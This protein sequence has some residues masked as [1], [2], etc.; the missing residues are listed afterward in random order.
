MRFDGDLC[1]WFYW[2]GI[3]AG[4]WWVL[5]FYLL[6][7]VSIYIIWSPVCIYQQS[8]HPKDKEWYFKAVFGLHRKQKRLCL[9]FSF[10]FRI[11][12]IGSVSTEKCKFY[13]KIGSYST[14]YIFKNY[15]ITVFLTL[16]FQI[17]KISNI[18]IDSK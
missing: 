17:L 2:C 4:C 8:A 15:F 7:W 16:N 10:G 5:G 1:V 6:W 9:A 13:F 14:I 3:V 11:L 18:Q 12:F